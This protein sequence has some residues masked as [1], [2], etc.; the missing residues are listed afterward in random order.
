MRWQGC[1]V[2]GHTLAPP[3]LQGCPARALGTAGP[4]AARQS[5][6]AHPLH[7]VEPELFAPEDLLEARPAA[8]LCD[9]GPAAASATAGPSSQQQQQQQ[10]AGAHR[11]FANWF[12]APGGSEGPEMDGGESPLREPPFVRSPSLLALPLGLALLQ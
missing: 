10:A 6:H 8:L 7:V 9:G 12:G 11:W 3:G 2:M 4:Q 1:A 5:V